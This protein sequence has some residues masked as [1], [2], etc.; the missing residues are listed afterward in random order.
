MNYYSTTL[1]TK[2]NLHIL[3]KS[4]YEIKLTTI[5]NFIKKGGIKT[6]YFYKTKSIEYYLIKRLFYEIKSIYP[7]IQVREIRMKASIKNRKSSILIKELSSIINVEK[8][9]SIDRKKIYKENILFEDVNIKTIKE[10]FLWVAELNKV[11][12]KKYKTDKLDLLYS[13]REYSKFTNQN[14]YKEKLIVPREEKE[15]EVEEFFNKLFHLA[16]NE[17]PFKLDFSQAS[18]QDY[19]KI[20]NKYLSAFIYV[21]ADYI[22]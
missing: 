9:I 16:E 21:N 12:K 1:L 4:L 20:K 11:N 5:V 17:I 10:L 2:E 14:K 22:L 6:F 7:E 18:M 19:A 15:K 3:L 8:S 13:E